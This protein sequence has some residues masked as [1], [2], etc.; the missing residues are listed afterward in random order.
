[1]KV[2]GFDMLEATIEGVQNLNPERKA[3]KKIFL[4]EN[5]KKTERKDLKDKLKLWIELVNVQTVPL[6][7][8]LMFVQR[9]HKRLKKI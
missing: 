9:K 3:R 4:T 7:R 8:W 6:L 5:G 2:G 1:M